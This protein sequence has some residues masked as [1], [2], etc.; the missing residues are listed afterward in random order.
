MQ[1]ARFENARGQLSAKKSA[2]IIAELKR[3]SGDIDILDK[4]IALE[5]AISDSPLVLG[6]K[7]TLLQDGKATYA[8]M[9][10][11]IRQAQRSHQ[12]RVL[13]YRRRPGRAG[14]RGSVAGAAEP[15][16]PVNVVY[17]SI[18]GLNYAEG[19]LR[20]TD[21]SRHRGRRIQSDQPARGEGAVADKQPRPPEIG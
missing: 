20:A 8:A 2:A 9:F 12:S 21:E 19:F 13:H 7:L 16:S 14:V 18:G 15:G 1:A 17:D 11:A 10:A 4:Q 6:N 3:K 5:Q